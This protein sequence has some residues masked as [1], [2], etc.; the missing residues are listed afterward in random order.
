MTPHKDEYLELCAGY[1]L[2][3]LTEEEARTVEAHLAE[4]CSACETEINRLGRGAMAFASATPRLLEPS[5]L[6]ARVLDTVRN[7]G[8]QRDGQRERGRERRRPIPLPPRRIAPVLG[9]MGAVAA[10]LIAAFALYEWRAASRLERDLAAA[11]QEVSRLNQQIQSEREWAAVAT[12]PQT[13]TIELKPTPA[14]QPQLH[15]RVTYD[16]ATRRAL[17]AVS[18]FVT[19]PGKDYQL[20]AI[21]KTGPMSLGLLR[22]DPQGRA[23]IRLDD[24]GDPFTLAAF[25]VSLEN[26]GGAPTPTAPAGPVV[27]VGKIGT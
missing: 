21:T 1:V 19:P 15:A 2:G 23:L 13:R 9:W 14:G 7:D 16:P 20:W 12:A 6:R 8:G 5:S 4:G 24:A 22:T 10:V 26:A 11:R 18:D 3:N 17:V 27:M 25:A